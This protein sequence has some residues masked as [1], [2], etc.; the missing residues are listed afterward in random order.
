MTFDYTGPDGRPWRWGVCVSNGERVWVRRLC[1]TRQEA[2]RIVDESNAYARAN[3]IRL[4][5]QA[6]RDPFGAHRPGDPRGW[7]RREHSA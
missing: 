3:R 7:Q 1:A 4:S 6:H 5:F 2:K